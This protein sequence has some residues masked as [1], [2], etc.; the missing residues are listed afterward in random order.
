MWP[1]VPNLPVMDPEFSGSCYFR[2]A[3]IPVYGLTGIFFDMSDNHTHGKDKRMGVREFYEGVEFTCRVMRALA[4]N[5]SAP[6]GIFYR[7]R[8]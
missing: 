2:R 4:G 1:G 8:G 7:L 6:C 5:W 3:G